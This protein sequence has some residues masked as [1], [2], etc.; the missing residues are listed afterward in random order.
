MKHE[1]AEFLAKFY[2]RIGRG[3]GLS[4]FIIDGVKM[5]IYVG[6]G[7]IIL[8][9][10]FGI[11]LTNWFIPVSGILYTIGC[12]MLGWID[13]RVGFWKKQ[14]DYSSKQLTPF[15]EKMGDKI[16]FI[17]NNLTQTK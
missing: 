12:Y 7:I 13:E 1:L 11:I 9:S 14:N 4:N 6:G 5:C 8:Q 10:R 16:D 3:A 15:F 2:L 17:Y